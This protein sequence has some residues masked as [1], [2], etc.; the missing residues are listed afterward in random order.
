MTLDLNNTLA[1][2]G[3]DAI[4]DTHFPAGSTVEIRTGAPAGAEGAAGGALLVPVVTPAAPWAVAAAGSK[5]KS[6]VWAA[7]ATGA[8][9]AGSFRM[10]NAAG[11]KLEEGTVTATGGGGDMTVDNTNVAIGQNVT[12]TGY[13][14][15][16]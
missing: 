8:G 14:R 12:I 5:A 13:T 15:T 2:L 11:T 7:A 10:K 6:G 16:L 3:L 4:Y 9:V 1:N